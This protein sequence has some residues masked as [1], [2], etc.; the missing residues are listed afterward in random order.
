MIGNQ[1][2]PIDVVKE[3]KDK[4]LH[5][6]VLVDIKVAEP[7]KEDLRNENYVP[8]KPK[9]MTVNECL[10]QFV[11]LGLDPSTKVIG[12]ARLGTIHF[13]NNLRNYFSIVGKFDFGQSLHSVVIPGNLHFME[14]Q[15]L[16]LYDINR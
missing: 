15:A 11:E 4:G 14:E 7:T 3:N 13:E 2:P 8:Q 16:E 1:Q 6:L 5:T 12:C 10:K 9:F